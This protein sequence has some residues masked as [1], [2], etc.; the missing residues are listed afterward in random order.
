[1]DLIFEADIKFQS[2]E[3]KNKWIRKEAIMKRHEEDFA[4]PIMD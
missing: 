4:H 1:M 2:R 3:S